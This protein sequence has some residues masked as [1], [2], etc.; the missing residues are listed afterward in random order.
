MH[1]PI[2]THRQPPCTGFRTDPA[3]MA[4]AERHAATCLSIPCNPQLTDGDVARVIGAIN[5]F[6][7]SWSRE[8]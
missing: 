2:P 1:Y 6:R 5:D 4:R 3:G 8:R 7:G